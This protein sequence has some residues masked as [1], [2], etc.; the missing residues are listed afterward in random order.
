MNNIHILSFNETRLS[1]DVANSE[2][3]LPGYT[4]VRR[5]R[6]SDGG[7]VLLAVCNDLDFREVS[8]NYVTN[9]EAVS[10]KVLR[11]SKQIIF[12]SIYR[13]PSADNSYFNK[14]LECIERL[15]SSAYD[16]VFLGDFN[17]NTL[18]TRHY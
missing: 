7:G 18:Q 16:V 15:V 9:I 12:S 3:V 6:N 14:L 17:L 1:A 8:D 5:D 13:P 4:L 10:V 11:G 2:I